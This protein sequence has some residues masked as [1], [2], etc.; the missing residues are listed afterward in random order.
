MKQWAKQSG[1]TIVEL[2]IVIVVIAILAAITIV[3]YTGIQNRA[4]DSAVQS[5][6]TN[7][8]KKVESLRVTA[9]S[10]SA[11]FPLTAS[12]G[13]SV[14]KS[15]YLVRNNLYYCTNG[16]Q[17]AVGGISKS[18][19]GYRYSTANGLQDYAD[20]AGNVYG[21]AI[22]ALVGRSP[23]SASYGAYAL[24]GTTTNWAGWVNG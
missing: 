7:F 3:A 24:D 17:F 2:L 18:G 4:Y 6:I 13:I 19:R 12:D 14:S 15:A 8:A 23:F 1:F 10:S 5:D 11:P 20:G 21:D 22:C 9:A 16:D